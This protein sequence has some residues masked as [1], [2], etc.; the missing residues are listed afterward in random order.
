VLVVG[1]GGI[2]AAVARKFT[3]LGA[4]V[5]GIRRNPGRGVPPGFQRIAGPEAL[6]A[7]LPGADVIV[8]TTPLTPETRTLLDARRLALL[9]PGA[10]VS[11]IGR[12]ALVDEAALAGAL[13]SGRVR[14][15]ALD[16]FGHEPL[17]SDSPLWHLPQVL[18]TPHVAG[19]SPRLFWDRLSAFFLDNWTRYRAGKPL[20]NLVDKH[21]GY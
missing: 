16:V 14:G 3:A 2:G 10:I 7:E 21:A 13:R 20:L 5:V 12:G 11:N 19:V 18:H 4:A 15:A 9:P 6:D 8:L 1:A 17:A